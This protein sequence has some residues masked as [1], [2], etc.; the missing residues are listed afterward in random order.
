MG[1]ALALGHEHDWHWIW[2][3]GTN[4]V[5]AEVGMRARRSFTDS[6]FR[7]RA[8]RRQDVR[9]SVDLM[10]YAACRIGVVVLVLVFAGL[11]VFYAIARGEF[12][13][14]GGAAIA[15]QLFRWSVP[16]RF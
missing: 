14:V 7:R 12:L 15:A 2:K 8:R 13:P 16:N 3:G 5:D 10:A 4:P 9:E 11:A 6:D 1:L